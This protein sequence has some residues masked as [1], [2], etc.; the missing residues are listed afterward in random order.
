MGSWNRFPDLRGAL[1][2]GGS[3]HHFFCL[4]NRDTHSVW[5]AHPTLCAVRRKLC[6]NLLGTELLS[7]PRDHQKFWAHF[8]C[9]LQLFFFFF[10]WDPPV[11]IQTFPELLNSYWSVFCPPCL[12]AYLLLI[13]FLPCICWKFIWE[14]EEFVLKSCS[15]HGYFQLR[16]NSLPKAPLWEMCSATLWAP[17]VP[18]LQKRAEE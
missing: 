4:G 14:H 10:L 5:R 9:K 2:D 8:L 1:Q 6:N 18:S 16:A 3:E 7:V 11:G 15:S 12:A 13:S 17:P